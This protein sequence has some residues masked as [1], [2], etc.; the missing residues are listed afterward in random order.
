MQLKEFHENP[1]VLHIG[2]EDNRAYYIPYKNEK[3]DSYKLL[4]DN[5]WKFMWHKNYLEVSDEFIKGK[6]D[7]YDVISVPSCVNILGYEKHQY[8]NVTGPIP[9]DP[10]YVPRENPCGTYVKEFTIDNMEEEHYLNFEG[11]DSC[12]YLW[13]NGKF[14]GYSQV[15]H[16]TSEFNITK[17]IVEGN[18]VMSIL[19]FKWCDGTYF[20]DQDKLRMTG[21]FRD[22]YILS[23]PKNHLRD[24]TINTDYKDNVGIIEI[25]SIEWSN[26]K[27]ALDFNLYDNKN[28]LIKSGSIDDSTI[29]IEVE[30]PSLWSAEEPN[31]YNIVLSTADEKIEQKVGIRKVEIIDS[32]L[33]LN[34]SKIKF[35]GVNRHDSDP[36]TGYCISKEQLIKDLKLMKEHNI[37]AI[38]TS[39]YPNAPWAYDLYSEYG[40]YVMDEADI[41][42]HNTEKIYGGGRSDYNYSNQI[43]VSKSFGLLCS[44]ERYE[45]TILD[46]VQRCVIRDKNHPCVVMWSLGN[47]SGYGPNMEKAAEWIKKQNKD[48]LI[49]F[50]S[51]IYQ[52]PDH[53]N[54]LSNIDVYSR[55]Y[56]PV[57]ESTEYCENNPKKPLVLCE[58]SHAMGNSSGDLEDYFKLIYEYDVFSGGFV[59]EWCDH[60]IYNGMTVDGKDKFLYGG[61]FGEFPNEGNFCMD[62]LV[63]PNRKP[64]TGLIEFKNVAR[65]VRASYED[66]KIIL[67][68]KMDF[69][70]VRDYV[71][72][73]WELY[74]DYENV[75]SGVISDLNIEP[76]QSKEVNIS[77]TYDENSEKTVYIMISYIQKNETPLLQ[78]GYCLGFDQ[79]ILKKESLSCDIEEKDKITYE[80]KGKK[81]LVSGENF[82][83]TFDT[84]KGVP[85]AIVCNNT[86]Y[87]DVPMEYNVWRAPVDNDRKI[88]K[89]WKDAGYDR[90]TVR[91]Y[92]DEVYEIDNAVV[93]KFDLGIGS[94]FLQNFLRVDAKYIVYSDGT[95]KIDLDAKKDMVFPYLPRFGVRMFLPKSFNMVDYIGYGPYESYLDKLHLDYYGKFESSVDNLH[96]DYIKPQENGSHCGCAYMKVKDEFNEIS[97]TGNDF[98]F[99]VSNY[100]Q[101]I[102]Q[103]T[104]HN[105]E[106]KKSDYSIVCIDG[107]MS[108][109]G[110][111]SCGPV[112]I[113]DYRVD[114]ENLSL[115]TTIQFKKVR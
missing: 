60:A 105:Y 69:V 19:V 3:N 90:H 33:Y 53:I 87:T 21:I 28:N 58:Y 108:G 8:A 73:K 49:H 64:H 75:Q 103:S 29:K 20:E 37:N 84:W 86:I 27:Q 62:G 112:L 42:T 5:N 35:K 63:Y 10:P 16:S 70:N 92:S 24:F 66:G 113:E 81:I 95:M 83:Y 77:F 17:Y 82:N 85:E 38:R 36:Y 78:K 106:L 34:G 67:S 12:F 96:E 57:K 43:I 76:H 93:V 14:V 65:P 114:G 51:S 55:M 41:E 44:D 98:S 54:D 2:T 23:R 88:M 52:M 47:E 48:Y 74:V 31:L 72:I 40:F 56:M 9:F 46:R 13:I 71:D 50:E 115:E 104:K 39:H 79:V 61:D 22:V 97:F 15:S 94:Q 91:V 26:E 68:N 89:Q 32:V 4:S 110:S 109:M 45:E 7:K 25:S 11:V 111:G 59:W 99:N 101:E 1:E 6:L 100:S 102:L 107:K 18:N 30:N 80:K